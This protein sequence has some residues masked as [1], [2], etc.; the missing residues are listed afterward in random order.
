MQPQS[1]ITDLPV[2]LA[3]LLPPTAQELLPVIGLPA[4]LA[5]VKRFGGTWLYVPT[6]ARCHAEHELAL[7]IGLDKLKALA[8]YYGGEALRNLPRCVEA[9]QAIRNNEIREQAKVMSHRAIALRYGMTERHV[10]NIVHGVTDGKN[11]NQS[12][13]FGVQ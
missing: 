1:L 10:R 5:L 2:C 4:T 12:D 3:H 6:L 13:M 9:L 8:A 11:D 7:L